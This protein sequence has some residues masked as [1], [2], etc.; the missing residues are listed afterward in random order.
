MVASVERAKI[1]PCTP[2]A[3]AA[4]RPTHGSQKRSGVK[5]RLTTKQPTRIAAQTMKWSVSQRRWKSRFWNARE[6]AIRPTRESYGGGPA[7]ASAMLRHAR[8]RAAP[9]L[10]HRRARARGRHRVEVF[11]AGGPGGQH[12]NKTQNGCACTTRRAASVVTATERRSLEANRRAAFERLVERLDAAQRRPEAAQGH[13]TDARLGRAPPVEHKDAPSRIKAARRRRH[14]RLSW[15]TGCNLVEAR[16]SDARRGTG[17]QRSRKRRSSPA[18]SGG[19]AHGGAARRVRVVSPLVQVFPRRCRPRRAGRGAGGGARRVGAV[20]DRRPRRRARAAR[21]ARRGDARSTGR[22]RAARAAALPRR[23]PRGD[24]RRRRV[25]GHAGPWP[26]PLI[27]DV[28]ALRRREAPRV[29]LR[30]AG[31]RDARDLGRAVRAARRRRRACYRG[32]VTRRRR[33]ARARSRC[34]IELHGARASRCRRRR[35]CR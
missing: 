15:P 32:A 1:A 6:G 13:A 35:R 22:A 12:R 24:A 9:A 18:R 33:R 11:T 2:S 23:V 3:A 8:R 10:R 34:P 26:D 5:L 19:A 27:P 4:T 28:D 7:H 17:L 30:R 29:P 25:E 21:R 31:R 20:P 14:R 16:C